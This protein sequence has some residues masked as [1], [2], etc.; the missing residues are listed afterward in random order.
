MGKA[1]TAALLVLLLVGLVGGVMQ[2]S[3]TMVATALTAD[4]AAGGDTVTV[5]STEGF[6]DSGIIVVGDEHI[7]Y[8]AI[9]AT[10]FV[11]S[12]L[13]AATNPLVR[14]TDGTED[15]AHSAG[16]IVRTKTTS[17]VNSSIDYHVATIADA[18]GTM[19]FV[20]IPLA[21]LQL[22][23]NLMVLPVGFLGTDLQ[24]LTYIWA[25]V[26]VGILV[27]AGIALAGGRRV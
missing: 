16:E 17:L 24:I 5:A 7:A 14:G 25:T 15:V 21:I 13:L 11:G 19:A 18:A 26:A 10:T 2:G 12:G 6:N 27:S 1:I 8:S 3:T 20:T 9:T 23:V 22:L 4:L